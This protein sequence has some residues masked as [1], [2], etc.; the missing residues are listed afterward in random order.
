MSDPL[1]S[2]ELTLRNAVFFARN[3]R[4]SDGDWRQVVAALANLANEQIEAFQ[5]DTKPSKDVDW[6]SFLQLLGSLAQTALD[7]LHAKG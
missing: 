1:P 5:N 3:G 7:Q 4:P 6:H 2:L